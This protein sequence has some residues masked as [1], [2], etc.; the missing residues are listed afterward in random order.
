MSNIVDQRRVN[1][2]K[3]KYLDKAEI[4]FYEFFDLISLL[5]K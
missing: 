5:S 2:A 4:D 1:F 3:F